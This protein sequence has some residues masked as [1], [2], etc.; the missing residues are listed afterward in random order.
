VEKDL[1]VNMAAVGV[2]ADN[3]EGL[4]WGPRLPDG[5][6]ALLVVAH[7]NFSDTQTTQFLLFEAVAQATK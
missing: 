5:N 6:T 7:D 3:L 1:L 2:T 4:A